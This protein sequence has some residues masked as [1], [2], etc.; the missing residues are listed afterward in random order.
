MT[1]LGMFLLGWV[2]LGF[3]VGVPIGFFLGRKA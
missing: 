1:Q 2:V 3:I